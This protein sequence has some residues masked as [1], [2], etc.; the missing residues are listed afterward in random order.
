[1]DRQAPP[2]LIKIHLARISKLQP[3]LDMLYGSIAY[4]GSCAKSLDTVKPLVDDIS[5]YQDWIHI[6]PSAIS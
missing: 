2:S 3:M 4:I 1:M 6:K 5:Y